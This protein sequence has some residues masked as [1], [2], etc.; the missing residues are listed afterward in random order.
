MDLH[1]EV[2]KACRNFTD[3]PFV[4]HGCTG[5][6]EQQVRQSLE[7]GVAKINFGTQIRTQYVEYLREGLAQKIDKGHAWRLS[8]YASDRLVG[9]V[10][11]IIR[12]AGSEGKA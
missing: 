10:Q 11:E 7:F 9:D 1:L 12:L 8:Q 3:I 4:L 5:M 6:A 2:L